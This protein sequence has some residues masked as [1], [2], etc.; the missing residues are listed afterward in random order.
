MVKSK[1]VLL[2]STWRAAKPRIKQSVR[3]SGALPRCSLSVPLIQFTVS[4]LTK[5]RLHAAVESP[6]FGHLPVLILVVLQ[7][8]VIVPEMAR[9]G[10]TKEIP[11]QKASI[12]ASHSMSNHS[13]PTAQDGSLFLPRSPAQ[14][15]LQCVV[16]PTWH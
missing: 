14:A 12:L 16:V 13:S 15:T 8:V 2:R 10:L 4:C 3:I 1:A 11:R 9:L 7:T 5:P 6:A